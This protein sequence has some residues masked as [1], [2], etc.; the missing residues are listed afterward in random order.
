MITVHKNVQNERNQ[1][2]GEG[3]LAPVNVNMDPDNVNMDP[4]NVNMDP[5]NVNM[6]P[7][8][9]N[10]D[11]DNVNMDP[12]N[13]IMLMNAV[14]CPQC[15]MYFS[16]KDNMQVHLQSGSCKGVQNPLECEKCHEVYACRQ[17]LSRHRKECKGLQVVPASS[18]SAVTT[19]VTSHIENHAHTQNI[20]T[21]I[22]TQ[23]NTQN[24]TQVLVFP[25][26]TDNFDFNT[27]HMDGKDM[28]RCID[29]K[30]PSIGFSKFVT[31]VLEN[32]ANLIAHK[33][34]PNVAYTK[35]HMGD[36][37]W[38]H[39]LDSE[40]FPTM[41]HHMTTA[42]LQ[43][44]KEHKNEVPSKLKSKAQEL[45]TYID[46]LNT[47]DEGDVYNE[48]IQRLKLILIDICQDN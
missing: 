33:T 29:S 27:E 5:V 39:E 45:L 15:Y 17:S 14:K 43:K 40:V 13:V 31:K 24:I 1:D 4:V 34:N 7:D 38:K 30:K 42:A 46:E 41:N 19:S 37:K 47:T 12:P 6:D 23:N 18:S 2:V 11:P 21:Q 9:V 22:G 8:N 28:N 25:W 32:P 44:M 36:G 35:I 26:D 3:A 20:E 48:S 16:R 10:M